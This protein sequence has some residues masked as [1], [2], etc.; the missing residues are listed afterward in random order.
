M[1]RRTM[2]HVHSTL[3]IPNINKYNSTLLQR[4]HVDKHKKKGERKKI[5]KRICLDESQ[6]Y[7]LVA[8]GDLKAEYLKLPLTSL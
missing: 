5:N 2:H 6:Q 7:N 1:K 3:C 8:P 4:M